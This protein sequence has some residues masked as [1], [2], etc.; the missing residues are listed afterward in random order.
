[1][2][3]VTISAADINKLRQQT[4][5]GMLDCRAAL[6]ETAGDFEAAIDFLRKKGQKMAA[7][8]SDRDA[9]EG[10]VIAKT[11]ADGTVGIIMNLTS[12][13][14]FVS[15]NE[16]FQK[17]GL[18]LSEVALANNCKSLEELKDAPMN[19]VKVS[20]ILLETVAKIGEKIDITVFSRVEAPSVVAYNH[21]AYRVGVLIGL[22]QPQTDALQAAGRDLAMQCAAMNPVAINADAVPSNVVDREKNIIFE[23]MKADPKMEGKSDEMIMKIAEGKLGA[24]FKENTL[25]AQSFV[26]DASKSVADYV[27]SVDA[28][29]DVV[30]MERVAIG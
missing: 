10:V 3:T 9:S 30:A 17:L 11:S 6:Q 5:A 15:K 27:K 8:R 12:E 18:D 22:N 20:D 7:K 29:L 1:M 21:G 2:S 23:T 16:D 24:F 14:D 13:T 25:L 28:N 26:K 19:G 4:G